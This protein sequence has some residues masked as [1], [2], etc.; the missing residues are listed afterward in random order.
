MERSAGV[1]ALCALV[2]GVLAAAA[3]LRGVQA[4]VF[5]AVLGPLGAA[6]LALA[7]AAWLGREPVCGPGTP[8]MA[9]YDGSRVRVA[10]RHISPAGPVMSFDVWIAPD[11]H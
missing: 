8:G 11:E 7:G 5:P 1:A 9:P 2:G 6:V 10:I 3:I 4:R